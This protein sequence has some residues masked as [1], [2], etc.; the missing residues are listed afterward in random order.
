MNEKTHPDFNRDLDT[1]G[2][3]LILAVYV[4]INLA[5]LGNGLV[6]S[7]TVMV[8]ENKQKTG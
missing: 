5:K 2:G 1:A 7:P 8:G 3:N 6:E 4:L